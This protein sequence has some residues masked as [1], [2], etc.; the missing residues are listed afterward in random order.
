MTESACDDCDVGDEPPLPWG[1]YGLD[2]DD[3]AEW[4][5]DAAPKLKKPA[6][7]DGDEKP[8]P[9]PLSE[10][11]APTGAD[12]GP[13][14]ELPPPAPA[15]PRWKRYRSRKLLNSSAL[16]GRVIEPPLVPAAAPPADATANPG[17]KL[18]LSGPTLVA[19]L[20]GLLRTL[21]AFDDSLS[22]RRPCPCRTVEKDVSDD[23]LER[24]ELVE[25]VAGL[26]GCATSSQSLVSALVLRSDGGGLRNLR[27]E[28]LVLPPPLATWGSGDDERG[29]EPAGDW[30]DGG[31]GAGDEKGE[32]RPRPSRNAG[33]T[34]GEN[35]AARGEA[36]LR[37]CADGD[38]AP[39]WPGCEL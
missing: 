26:H 39:Y 9:L 4:S 21:L 27:L 32:L 15:A 20:S 13:E 3:A 5:G 7:D 22:P 16:L 36:T 2:D 17:G 10:P 25:S 11:A 19:S 12:A 34:S 6:C 30:P 37:P 18:G 38:V 24:V 33:G 23:E 31:E 14:A 35:D 1:E 28:E 29:G 8:L